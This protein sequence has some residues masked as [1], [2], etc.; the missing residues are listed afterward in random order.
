MRKWLV[1]VLRM[2]GKESAA[3]HGAPARP[4]SEM[5][6]VLLGRTKNLKV[7][8]TELVIRFPFENIAFLTYFFI[9]VATFLSFT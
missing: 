4:E 2:A 8:N 1:A 6:A 3:G 7:T 5:D 9:H